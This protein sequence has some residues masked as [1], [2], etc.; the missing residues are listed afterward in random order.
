MARVKGLGLLLELKAW[1]RVRVKVLEL[2]IKLK[3]WGYDKG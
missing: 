1:V 2:W 3:V